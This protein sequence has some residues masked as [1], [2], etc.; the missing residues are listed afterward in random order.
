MQS[1]YNALDDIDVAAMDQF[2]WGFNLIRQAKWASYV[3][4]IG[5]TGV[6]QG[7]LCDPNYFDF[8]SFAQ[9]ATI[10]REIVDS[11]PVIFEEQQQSEMESELEAAKF[12]K[13]FLQE[14]PNCHETGQ[15]E[16]HDSSSPKA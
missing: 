3:G 12:K 8:I 14:K 16:H 10:V 13:G 4:S 6:Q 9:Y 11:P 1:S 7:D 5:S 15:A 2:Q